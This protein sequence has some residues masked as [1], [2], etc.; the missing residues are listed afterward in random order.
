MELQQKREPTL[1]IYATLD[2]YIRAISKNENT[3]DR[4]VILELCEKKVRT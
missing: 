1:V 4:A 3:E 2:D